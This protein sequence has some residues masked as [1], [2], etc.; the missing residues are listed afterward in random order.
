MLLWRITNYADIIALYDLPEKIFTT[1]QGA[2]GDTLNAF[3]KK[4]KNA[5]GGLPLVIDVYAGPS[6]QDV[7]QVHD[8]AGLDA[9]L[10]SQG[11]V[12]GSIDGRGT[13]GRGLTFMQQTYRQLGLLEIA[14]QRAGAKNLAEKISVVDSS[15]VGIWGWSYGGFMA[16]HGSLATDGFNFKAAV[17]VAPV[18]DWSLYDT[19]YTERY[20][21]TP[22]DNPLGYNATSV[23]QSAS[24]LNPNTMLLMHG[25]ADDN[26]HFQNSA[27]FVYALIQANIPFETMYFPNSNHG[28]NAGSNSRRYL[29][30]KLIA[31]LNKNL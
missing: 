25:M 21:S 15:R 9:W 8:V 27:E 4:P 14:D 20:M 16:A 17:S 28:I 1:V 26:V 7:R 31:F 13:G 24:S 11:Y 3:Y 5:K 19:I 2:A 12:M 22:I 23:I 18:T 29:Y 6:T 30:Q 10:C